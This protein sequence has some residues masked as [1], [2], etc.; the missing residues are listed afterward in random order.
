MNAF[1]TRQ[2]LFKKD[3]LSTAQQADYCIASCPGEPYEIFEDLGYSGK[4]L[5]RPGFEK[6]ME[7]VRSGQITKILVYKLDRISRNISD[8]ANLLC[9]LQ[10]YNCEFQSVSENFDTTTPIGRAMI[11]ICMIFAQMERENTSQRVHDNYYYRTELGFW[12]GGVAPYGY[13]LAKIKYK[14]KYHTILEP[15][16]ETAPLVRQL[17]EWYLKPN[18]SI[19][20]ILHK[21]N[22]ELQIPSRKGGLWSSRVLAD[23]LSR[24]LY[25]PNDMNIY[26]YLCGL[27]ATITNPPKDFDGKASVDLYGKK[28]ANANKHKRTRSA[29]EMYCNVSNHDAL[30][31]SDTWLR[32]QYKHQAM[33]KT[34]SRAGTGK[35]SWFTGLMKCACCG[36]G[37]SYTNSHGTQGYYICSS[38]KNR[39]YNSCNQKPAPKKK[40]DPII[41]QSII[42]YYSREDVVRKIKSAEFRTP[43]KN[44]ADLKERNNLMI[45]LNQIQTEISNL[46][47]SLSDGSANAVLIRYVNERIVELDSNKSMITARISEIDSGQT[48]N[49]KELSSLQQLESVLNDIP[50]ILTNGTFDE[51]K[52]LCHILVKKI[53]FDDVGNIDIEYTVWP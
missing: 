31:D 2:S 1:Y 44:T 7:K 35:N 47:Q 43:E 30:V 8:F 28:S 20:T 48:S 12:G 25:A 40:V 27:G 17:Y 42:N 10:Q 32:V 36:S 24:P 14:G 39:G 26:N 23:I 33:L 13:K 22:N 11:Y 34:P 9:E 6:M 16:E 51:I 3:S 21:L 53:S 52:N 41:I 46:M 5:N 38:R 4:N 15:D 29:S 49:Q 45:Q 37:V 19:S 50:D 18:A